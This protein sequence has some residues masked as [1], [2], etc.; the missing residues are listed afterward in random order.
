MRIREQTI[1]LRDDAEPDGI[2]DTVDTASPCG[3]S[4]DAPGFA[5]GVVADAAAAAQL[6]ERAVEV[7]KICRPANN[8]PVVL[9]PEPA[10]GE[11]VWISGYAINPFDVH[12][13]EKT[14][15]LVGWSRDLL[16]HDAVDH[17]EA[18]SA[19]YRRTS[20][21]ADLGGT[22]LTQQTGPD[23]RVVT[24]T[25]IDASTGAFESMSTPRRPPPGLGTCT[26]TAGLVGRNRRTAGPA[27]REDGR[28]LGRAGPVRPGHRSDELWLTI[29]SRS[30]THR[31]RPRARLRGGLRGHVVR[32]AR[33]LGTLRYGS[34]P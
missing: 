15:L 29:T 21:F 3:W 22:R 19:R 33:P 27:R 31:A 5:G 28:A 11:Q 14:G 13:A 10:H 16:A 2:N 4:N 7:A 23:A 20:S 34:R 12:D 17:V 6:A 25:G 24:V 9:A 26:A 30:A 8:E 18:K 32:D 1:N